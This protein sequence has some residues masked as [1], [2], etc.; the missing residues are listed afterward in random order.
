[1]TEPDFVVVEDD[2]RSPLVAVMDELLGTP[3]WLNID[4]AIREE[5]VP[6]APGPIGLLFTGRGPWVPRATWVPARFGRRPDPMSIGI[7]HGSGPKAAE[8]LVEKGVEIPDRWRVTSDH[9]KRG[10]V[11][12]VPVEEVNATIAD[13]I[14]AAVQ[15]LTIVPLLPEWRVAVYRG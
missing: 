4:P 10:V 5:H 3:G 1:V 8:R 13:W 6:P 15:A 11:L 2:D 9:P 7:L 14:C 12:W